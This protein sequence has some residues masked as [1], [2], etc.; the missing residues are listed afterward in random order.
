MGLACP[1]SFY[2]FRPDVPVSGDLAGPAPGRF[3]GRADSEWCLGQQK[4]VMEPPVSRPFFELP[5]LS[6]PGAARSLHPPAS[7][8]APVWVKCVSQRGALSHRLSCGVGV[9]LL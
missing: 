5:P 9:K 3:I 7:S 1:L 8:Q 6:S 2:G 4:T